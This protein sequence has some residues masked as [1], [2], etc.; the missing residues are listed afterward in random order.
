[1]SLV[2]TS[3]LKCFRKESTD[4]AVLFV[5]LLAPSSPPVNVT[6][7]AHDS[8]TISVAWQ[9][10]PKEYRNG[11]IIGYLSF[12]DDNNISI[13]EL[14]DSNE[15]QKFYNA[16]QKLPNG[17]IVSCWSTDDKNA[18]ICGA[19]IKL[20]DGKEDQAQNVTF[21][22]LRKFT[23]YW[24]HVGAETSAGYSISNGI[25]E[26]TTGEDGKKSTFNSFSKMM[27][28]KLNGPKTYFS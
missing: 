28:N 11:K 27:K 22:R 13:A 15:V 23:T 8:T 20:D 14:L 16:S 21:T 1:M 26:V 25:I 19:Y 17:T 5:F 10:V 6:V 18:H 7:V 4:I 3:I 12:I 2:K 24:V 9:P